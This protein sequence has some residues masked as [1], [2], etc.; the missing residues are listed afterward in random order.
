MPLITSA[1]TASA[2]PDGTPAGVVE[3]LQVLGRVLGQ[4]TG[5]V[6][7]LVSGKEGRERENVL[8]LIQ[9]SISIMASSAMNLG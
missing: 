4:L 6:L 2:C 3:V 5:V 8:Q 1:D 7:D 9:D